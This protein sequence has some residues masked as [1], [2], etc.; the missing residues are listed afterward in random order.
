MRPRYH[1]SY[2]MGTPVYALESGGERG[3]LRECIV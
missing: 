2:H 3:G 1:D